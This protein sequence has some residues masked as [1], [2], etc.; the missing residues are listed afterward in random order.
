MF[1]EILF[2]NKLDLFWKT[3][4]DSW[5]K[6]CYFIQD[7]N[8]KTISSGIGQKL[9]MLTSIKNFKQFKTLKFI[10]NSLAYIFL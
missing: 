5:G 10:S 9:R 1:C 3:T 2:S 8:F 7:I 6:K 4:L